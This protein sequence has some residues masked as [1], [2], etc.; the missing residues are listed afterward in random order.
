MSKTRQLTG[1]AKSRYLRGLLEDGGDAAAALD[2]AD[3]EI[4]QIVITRAAAERPRRLRSMRQAHQ[5]TGSS[6]GN[7]PARPDDITNKPPPVTV[8]TEG[9][10]PAIAAVA[11]T[12]TQTTPPPFNPYGFSAMAVLLGEGRAALE[13][14]LE[15]ATT[16]E[17]IA[18]L[19]AAQSVRLDPKLLAN[20]KT[21]IARLRAACVE[22]V[23][24]RVDQ[25]RAVAG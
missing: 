22:A 12:A 6:R 9:A 13:A 5:M 20:P 21:G 14:R 7:P 4:A 24:K 8:T 18:Q 10:P 17:Q 16:R 15:A 3:S 19:A 25:R 11:T 23:E 2:R 1:R